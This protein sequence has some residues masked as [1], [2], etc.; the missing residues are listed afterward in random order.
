MNRS[1]PSTSDNRK[2]PAGI[3]AAGLISALSYAAL[4]S[5][6]DLTEHL[7]VFL[8]CHLALVA[9]MVAG[10]LLVRAGGDREL[11]T[12]AEALATAFGEPKVRIV[13]PIRDKA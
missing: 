4:A 3:L 12:L 13:P 2:R 6:G 11:A 10:W 5:T 9:L 8:G 7:P 1:T